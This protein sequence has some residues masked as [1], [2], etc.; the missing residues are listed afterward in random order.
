M[1][2]YQQWRKVIEDAGDNPEEQ[3]KL[4]TD[5]CK[6]EQKIYEKIL[7]NKIEMI[8]GQVEALASEYQVSLHYFVGFL[9]GINDSLHQSLELDQLQESSVIRVKINFPELYKNMLAVP[10]D[11][12]FNLPQWENILSREERKQIKKDFNRSKIVVNNNKIG[13]NDP[14]PC[15]SGKKYKKCC[16]LPN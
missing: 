16:G 14:C 11:W 10:A 8:E 1:S 15:G 5:F 9:D 7:E 13:R 3:Q 6:E 2:L 12:L 4:W